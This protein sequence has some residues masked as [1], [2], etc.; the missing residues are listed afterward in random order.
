MIP[1]RRDEVVQA[2]RYGAPTVAQDERGPAALLLMAH[3]GPATADEVPGFLRTLFGP[4]A[5]KER[6]AALEERYRAIGAF[7]PLPA[8]VQRIAAALAPATGLP[9]YVGMRYGRPSIEQAFFKAAADGIRLL[10]AVYVSPHLSRRT[11]RR[12]RQSLD[13]C[14]ASLQDALD[15]RYVCNWYRRPEYLAAEAEATRL[16]LGRFPSRERCCPHVVFSA[17]SLP[18]RDLTAAD[19]YVA[20]V[21][22]SAAG[23]ASAL[24]LPAERWCVAYQSAPEPGSAWLGPHI[25]EVIADLAGKGER[26][27][28]VVPLGFV[29]DSLEVL[30]DIDL[31]LTRFAAERGVHLER[32]PLL[33][34]GAA[35]VEAL[36]GAALDALRSVH[37]QAQEVSS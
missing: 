15:V 24:G 34:D 32:A 12:C 6:V 3:G 17:H 4:R 35:L 9:V 28:V 20:K 16:A 31:E 2:T 14:N 18:L 5:S 29:V 21:R 26:Q 7:S 27:I 1:A 33:N 37:T 25:H 13:L 36:K 30:Y 22:E 8:L 23:V 10:A 19:P 11:A